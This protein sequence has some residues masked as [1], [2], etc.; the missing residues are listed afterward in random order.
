MSRHRLDLA[1]EAVEAFT[2]DAI[3]DLWAAG[4]DDPALHEDVDAVGG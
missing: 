1:S 3:G 2:L 4:R